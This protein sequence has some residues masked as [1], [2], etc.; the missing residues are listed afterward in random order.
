MDYTKYEEVKIPNEE[1]LL[2]ELKKMVQN[3]I[4]KNKSKSREYR[5]RVPILKWTLYIKRR[6]G[7]LEEI[8][9]YL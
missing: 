5:P 1:E 4:G 6:D 3:E 8:K 2:D 7:T 9:K